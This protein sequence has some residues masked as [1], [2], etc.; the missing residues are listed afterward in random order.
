MNE[1]ERRKV[2]ALLCFY[3]LCS[4]ISAK[5]TPEQEDF[6]WQRLGKVVTPSNYS[7]QPFQ[8]MAHRQRQRQIVLETWQQRDV[9]MNPALSPIPWRADV[10][11]MAWRRPVVRYTDLME[12]Q[13]INRTTWQAASD[14][15]RLVF[16]SERS[17]RE[18]ALVGEDARLFCYRGQLQLVFNLQLQAWL[19]KQIYYTSLHYLPDTRRF[20][21][22]N[23][24]HK[25]VFP[26]GSTSRLCYYDSSSS[27]ESSLLFVY[28]IHPHRIVSL[29]A[30]ATLHHHLLLHHPDYY[31]DTAHTVFLTAIEDASFRW[32]WGELRGGSQAVAV[33]DEHYLA[34]FHS[35]GAL[36]GPHIHSYV[37]GAYLFERKPPFAIKKI[38]REPIMTDVFLNKSLTG[39]AYKGS[40]FIQF[41]VGLAV[42]KDFFFVSYGRNDRDVS[43]LRG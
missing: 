31:Q 10:L 28:S 14:K 38:T 4:V 1:V 16:W 39:W 37:M 19:T 5:V 7:L 40:D 22:G 34:V 23:P 43:C 27:S 24:V 2:L 3:L 20:I 35:S 13:L 25:M 41:P 30:N 18:E 26:V 42:E 11:L 17:G 9:L 36:H 12:Y 33:D 21:A 29:A 15:E 32:P 8:A 6:R